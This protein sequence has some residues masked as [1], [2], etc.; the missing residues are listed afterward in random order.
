MLMMWLLDLTYFG[1]WLPGEP[2]VW[3]RELSSDLQ[4]SDLQGW[5]RGLQVESIAND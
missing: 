4:G 1:G 3:I 2:T 5:E